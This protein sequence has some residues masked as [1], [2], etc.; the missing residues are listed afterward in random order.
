MQAATPDT[1]APDTLSPVARRLGYAGLLP[2]AFAVLMLFDG[3]GLEWLAMAG[4][5]GYA[6]FIF[7]FL[8]GVWWG[9]AL[10]MQNPP[11][12]IYAA[13]VLPS[14]ISLVAFL[15]WT[16]GWQWPGPSLWVLATALAVSPLVDRAIAHITPLPGGWMRLRWH[17]SLALGA[18]TAILALAA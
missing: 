8:G 5:F 10:R 2:Q 13:A 6:A 4:G 14:L 11:G 17:L 9:L 12:W 1:T 7:C 16:W 15:P 18:M 3:S